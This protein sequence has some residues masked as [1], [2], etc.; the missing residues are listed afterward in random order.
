VLVLEKAGKKDPREI[1]A[2]REIELAPE[3]INIHGDT[4]ML[5]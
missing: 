4:S 5:D 3:L 1:R 2:T